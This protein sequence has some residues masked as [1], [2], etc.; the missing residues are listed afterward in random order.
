MEIKGIM[1]ALVTGDFESGGLNIIKM[2]DNIDLYPYI[3]S[4]IK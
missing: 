3:T 1:Y 2:N 4:T